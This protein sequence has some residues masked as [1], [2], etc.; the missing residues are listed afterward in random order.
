MNYTFQ[1]KQIK[2]TAKHCDWCKKFTHFKCELEGIKKLQLTHRLLLKMNRETDFR[3]CKNYRYSKS[4][5]ESWKKLCEKNE[6][7]TSHIW[8]SFEALNQL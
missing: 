7:E 2:P 8:L 5:F 6:K 3:Y 4:N 1:R